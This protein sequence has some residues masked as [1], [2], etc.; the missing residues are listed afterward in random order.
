MKKM[1]SL[2]VTTGN[3][4]FKQPVKK[5]KPLSFKKTNQTSPPADEPGATTG[6]PQLKLLIDELSTTGQPPVNHR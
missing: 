2:R 5:Y 4:I 3:P 6:D 1:K